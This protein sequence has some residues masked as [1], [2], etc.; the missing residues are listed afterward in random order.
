MFNKKRGQ[1]LSLN[2]IV[3]TILVILVL[4]VVAVFFTG[5]F[6]NLGSLISR[7]YG[8]QLV[9]VSQAKLQCDSWCNQY[10]STESELWKNK[11]CN[12]DEN[13]NF[14]LDTDGDKKVDR[15]DETCNGN[16]INSQCPAIGSCVS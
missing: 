6:A 15:P 12:L 1:G 10:E 8:S 11:W 16:V 3:I 7:L 5:G 2:V 9:S 4:V 13:S 14:D